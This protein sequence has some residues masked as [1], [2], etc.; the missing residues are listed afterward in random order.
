MARRSLV[1]LLSL[2][3]TL[4]VSSLAA[5]LPDEQ[6]ASIRR[7]QKKAQDEVNTAHGNKKSSEMNTAERKQL[8]ADQQEATRKVL[9]KHGVS[10]KDYDRQTARMGPAGNARVAEAEKALEAR[11]KAAQQKP[12]GS[13]EIHVQ[14]GIDEN[15][16]AVLEEQ[17]G[18]SP[19]VE[20]GMPQEDQAGP[21]VEQ[22][23]PKDDSAAEA[24]AEDA[25]AK[26]TKAAA[27]PAKGGHKKR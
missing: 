5:D 8:I 6:I 13:G 17:E 3:V 1:L 24:A 9:D 7:D 27:K 20:H 4:P 18:A 15:H 11:E 23:L 25:A 12:A 26:A 16:P 22:G 21:T 19:M 10:A 2:G 14:Q